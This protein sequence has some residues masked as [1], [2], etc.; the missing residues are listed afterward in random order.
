MKY[1][2]N[3]NKVDESFDIALFK[4]LVLDGREVTFNSSE[5][6][7]QIQ[8]SIYGAKKEWCDE[9]PDLEE[10]VDMLAERVEQLGALVTK[11]REEKIADIMNEYENNC[12]AIIQ[13][14]NLPHTLKRVLAFIQSHVARGE[15]EMEFSYVTRH[16]NPLEVRYLVKKLMKLGYEVYQ[17]DRETLLTGYQDYSK[18]AYLNK[19]TVRWD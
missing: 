5:P 18:I 4:R 13:Q 1:K 3:I 14:P 8:G 7:G 12:M 17:S 11:L 6:W 19:V 15:T 16:D 2:L 10:K 9:V